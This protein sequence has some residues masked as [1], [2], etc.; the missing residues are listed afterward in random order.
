[1]KRKASLINLRLAGLFP[2]KKSL[3]LIAGGMDD[4]DSYTSSAEIVSRNPELSQRA[5]EDFPFAVESPVALWAN[6]KVLVCGG[7]PT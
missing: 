2:E 7:A 1:M 4:I 3:S 6:G 5:V